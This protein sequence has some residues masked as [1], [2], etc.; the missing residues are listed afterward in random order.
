[1]LSHGRHWMYHNLNHHDQFDNRKGLSHPL[2][3]QSLA[4][5][6][7]TSQSLNWK[8]RSLPLQLSIKS[9]KLLEH[10]QQCPRR[11]WKWSVCTVL[12]FINYLYHI[13]LPVSMV[14]LQCM[15]YITAPI[16]WA[17]LIQRGS[18]TFDAVEDCEVFTNVQLIYNHNAT[19]KYRAFKKA[20]FG[21]L[22][23]PVLTKSSSVTSVCIKECWYTCNVS[24]ERLAC[25]PHNQLIEL[26]KEINCLHWGSALMGIVYDFISKHTEQKGKP[27]FKIPN[28]RFV[29]S[30]LAIVDANPHN[31]APCKVFMIEEVIDEKAKGSYVKYIGNSSV[32]PFDFLTGDAAYWAQFLTFAQHLQY[33]KTCK[34]AFVGD[35]QNKLN[36]TNGSDAYWSSFQVEW[37]YWQIYR[38]SLHCTLIRLHRVLR[39][40]RDTFHDSTDIPKTFRWLC[41]LR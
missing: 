32:L 8:E 20:M 26:S 41:D 12:C 13:L 35:F 6:T 33:I 11:M 24:R 4:S 22:G 29:K 14:S 40:Y 18:T 21:Q 5:P 9:N 38:S 10:R 34:L 1:M 30:G 28:M 25:D 3:T 23:R 27:P 2:L 39:M 31:F 15:L 17:S 7:R 16:T 36:L 19:P 37:I